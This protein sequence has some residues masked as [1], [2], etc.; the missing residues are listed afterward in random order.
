MI[1][2]K[3]NFVVDDETGATF[4]PTN[5]GACFNATNARFRVAGVDLSAYASTD[6]RYKLVAKDTAL[7]KAEGYIDVADDAEALGSDLFDA[8]AGIFTDGTYS[9]V[10]YGTNTI[11]NDTNTLKIAYSNG[12]DGAYLLLRDTSDLSSNLTVG[13]LYKLTFDAK[14][15]TGNSVDIMVDT[16]GVNLTLTI[17]ETTFT[18][19]TIYFIASHATADYIRM[20]NMTTNEIIW[21]DNIVLKEVTNVG[22]DGVLIMSTKGGSTQSWALQESGIDLNDIDRFEVQRATRH[23]SM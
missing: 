6:N 16:T 22:E 2:H 12:A 17:T 19:K 20:G 23:H 7:K 1:I 21:L 14:V 5:A 13:K 11:A 4:W 3:P 18:S 9:W 8:G 15:D 10:V